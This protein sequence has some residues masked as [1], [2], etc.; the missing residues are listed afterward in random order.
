VSVPGTIPYCGSPYVSRMRSLSDLKADLTLPASRRASAYSSVISR[1]RFARDISRSTSS[2][3]TR[4][5]AMSG[6]TTLPPSSS[7]SLMSCVS[8]ERE[9]TLAADLA[10]ARQASAAASSRS[11]PDRRARC[12][13]MGAAALPYF[14]TMILAAM[15]IFVDRAICFDTGGSRRRSSVAIKSRS[16]R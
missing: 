4:S 7:E 8:F 5:A 3:S 2:R 15:P 14:A 12:R 6:L 11:R 10:I 1:R 16:I 13:A 9:S